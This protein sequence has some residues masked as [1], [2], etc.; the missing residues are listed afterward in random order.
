VLVHQT[1]GSA[2]LS[3]RAGTRQNHQNRVRKLVVE[4]GRLEKESA[5]QT[6][7]MT[8][9]EANAYQKEKKKIESSYKSFGYQY[10]DYWG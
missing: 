5:K 2:V 7:Q 10:G 3:P 6:A 4:R 1:A 8:K 9:R